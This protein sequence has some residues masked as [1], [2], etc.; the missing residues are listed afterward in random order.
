[1]YAFLSSS[2]R[3][4]IGCVS[5]V[6]KRMGSKIAQK[7]LSKQK[8]KKDR[9]DSFLPNQIPL[10]HD[11]EQRSHTRLATP[12]FTSM[13][14][15]TRLTQKLLLCLKKIMHSWFLSFLTNSPHKTLVQT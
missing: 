11:S 9:D 13:Y 6:M 3:N 4:I 10:K 14:N 8:S 2:E 15:E 12:D 1:M 5:K 7:L